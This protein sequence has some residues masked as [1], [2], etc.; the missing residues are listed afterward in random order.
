M[1]Q[2]DILERIADLERRI[3][4]LQARLPKHSVPTSMLVELDDLE[5]ELDTLKAQAR[6]LGLME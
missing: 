4:D 5:D 3:A 1:S 6:D 2:T